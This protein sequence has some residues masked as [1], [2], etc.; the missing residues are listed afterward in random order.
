MGHARL[1]W[2]SPEHW[3]AP[4]SLAVGP[5][6][7]HTGWC[8]DRVLAAVTKGGRWADTGTVA[9]KGGPLPP[10]FPTG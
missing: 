7:T 3:R 2:V 9:L 6:R 4:A 8:A 1:S 5:T 10:A